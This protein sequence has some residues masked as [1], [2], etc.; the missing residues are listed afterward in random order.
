MSALSKR[1]AAPTL[2]ARFRVHIFYIGAAQEAVPG[3]ADAA[4]AEEVAASNPHSIMKQRLAPVKRMSCMR[5]RPM[6]K[7]MKACD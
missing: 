5:S 1:L 2:Q 6:S 4:A 7:H 3:I